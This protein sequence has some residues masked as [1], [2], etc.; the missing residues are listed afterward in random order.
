[1]ERF[2]RTELLIG[3]E[4]L[5]KLKR[6]HVALFGIGGVGGHCA[7]ALV[8]YGIGAIDLIDKDVFEKSNLN[9]QLFA[10]T[11]TLNKPK[12]EVAKQNLLDINENLDINIFNLFYDDTT[13]NLFDFSKYDYVIDAIDCV[14]SKIN[15]IE[16]CK[17]TN[18]PII[19]AMGAGNKLNP[20]MLDVVDI[21]KT[22]NC[23]LA[24]V[25][26]YELKKRNIKDLKVVYSKELPKKTNA[27]YPTSCATVPAVMGLIIASVVVEDLIKQ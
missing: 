23:P 1:M 5:E 18:T 19:S 4:A 10:L 25:M 9:R 6:S 7:Q 14:K 12:V 21:F 17:Q 13:S 11:S 26:R 3:K 22:K 24:R 2:E 8:R 27:P 15:L 20:L 16:K